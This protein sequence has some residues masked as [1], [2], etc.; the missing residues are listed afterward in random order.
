MKQM[1]IS[2]ENYLSYIA[3]IYMQII[4]IRTNI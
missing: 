3:N 4:I 1:Y 2:D